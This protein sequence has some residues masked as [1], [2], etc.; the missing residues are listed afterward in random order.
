MEQA[1]LAAWLQRE[2][3][4]TLQA[5][6]PVGGGCIHRAWRLELAGGRRLFA[7][8]N[9]LSLQPVIQWIMNPLGEGRVPAI[10]TTALQLNLSL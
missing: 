10:V 3:G 5:M 4:E 6:A 9:R 8:T 7:K 1:Q 2:R